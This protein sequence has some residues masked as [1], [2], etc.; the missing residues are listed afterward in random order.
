[1]DSPK[2]HRGNIPISKASRTKGAMTLV[3]SNGFFQELVCI[4]G[5]SA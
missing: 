3:R 2:E 5:K 1:V 4:A